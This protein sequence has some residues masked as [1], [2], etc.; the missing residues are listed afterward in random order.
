VADVER[1]K[2][3]DEDEEDVSPVS[4]SVSCL[5]QHFQD[6]D[7][8]AR[9]D[10]QP[11]EGKPEGKPE[12]VTISRTADAAKYGRMGDIPLRSRLENRVMD[13]RVCMNNYQ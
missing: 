10:G 12:K 4:Q 3:D 8:D 9:G 6:E 1:P 7:N 11:A 13:L 5:T 2:D